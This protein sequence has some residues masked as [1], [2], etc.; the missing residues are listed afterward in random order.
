MLKTIDAAYPDRAFS[1]PFPFDRS[2]VPSPN[3]F[4]IKSQ[5]EDFNTKCRCAGWLGVY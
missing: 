2:K 4:G 3:G 1:F 5:I